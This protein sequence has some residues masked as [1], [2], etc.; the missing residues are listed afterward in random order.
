M[1]FSMFSC[2][3]PYDVLGLMFPT[4]F[5]Q[6]GFWLRGLAIRLKMAGP[7]RGSFLLYR[8]QLSLTNKKWEIDSLIGGDW[9]KNGDLMGFNGIYIYTILIG[10]LE[11]WN[12]E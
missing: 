5:F 6:A 7:G 9:N 11:P 12:F 10:G 2:C 4:G 3:S 1:D 8:I